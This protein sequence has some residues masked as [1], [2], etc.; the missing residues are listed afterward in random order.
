MN[1]L[2]NGSNNKSRSKLEYLPSNR[3]FL[4]SKEIKKL[5]FQIMI[6]MSSTSPSLMAI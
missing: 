1:I 5:F 6:K 4:T 2:S 3:N